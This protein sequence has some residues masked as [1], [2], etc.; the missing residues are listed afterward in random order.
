V[1]GEKA[2]ANYCSTGKQ[3]YFLHD[4][5]SMTGSRPSDGAV[6]NVPIRN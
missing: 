5:F 3:H 4:C 1:C 2:H 6:I